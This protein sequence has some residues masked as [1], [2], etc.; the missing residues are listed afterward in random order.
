MKNLKGI[1][2]YK[3]WLCVMLLVP[4]MMAA[5]LPAMASS[6]TYGT[7]KNPNGGNYVNLREW[8]SYDA[9]VLKCLPVGS[10][11]E[12]VRYDG[13]WILVRADGTAGFIAKG[14]LATGTTG[15][16]SASGKATISVGPLNMR[17]APS[18]R[19][20]VVMQ[21]SSGA[22]VTVL[23][24]GGTWS[25]IRVNDACGYVVTSALSFGGSAPAPTPTNPPKAPVVNTKNANATIKTANGGNL[26]LRAD[27]SESAAVIASFGNG[28]RIRVLT[29]GS[30]W[31][32]VQAGDQYGYMVTKYLKFDGF[33]SGGSGSGSAGSNSGKYYTA[34]VNNPG[35]SQ[36]LNLRAKPDVNSKSLAQFK[37]GTQV[38]VYGIGTEW[39]RVTVGGI[40]GYMLAKYVKITSSAATPHKTVVNGGSFVNLRSGPGYGYDVLKKV[41]DGAAATIV[42]PQTGW[43]K[44]IVKDGNG[45]MTGY[46]MSSFLK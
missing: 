46:M 23:S 3:R 6:S 37:N 38:K 42:I 24:R 15:G 14:F 9:P 19:A 29:H 32:R 36:V 33:A 4:V 31:C 11:V 35:A 39:L 18:Q 5:A 27:A 20:R 30:T 8:G 12:I 43:S 41:S 26:N 16:G 7:V 25:Q 34:V 45:Y 10:T 44:V 21:L 22:E 40:D 28:S 2:T 17:E 1:L 13:A